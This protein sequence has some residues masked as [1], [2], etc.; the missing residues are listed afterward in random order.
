[1]T[2]VDF[3][4]VHR[5][6]LLR[7]NLEMNDHNLIPAKKGE[8]RNPKGRPKG[9]RNFKTILTEYLDVV[10]KAQNP[11]SG[12]VEELSMRD[13]IILQLIAKA[14]AGDYQAIKDLMDREMGKA[15]ES[16]KLTGD[17]ENPVAITAVKLVRED[18]QSD[19]IE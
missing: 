14:Q 1:M 3:T 17:T 15:S 10:T 12:A 11:V 19:E 9:A 4:K 2:A 7:E 5:R 13:Q 8:V 6:F 18:L 16:V